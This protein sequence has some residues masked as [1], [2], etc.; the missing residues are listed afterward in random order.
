MGAAIGALDPHAVAHLHLGGQMRA[1]APAGNQ[2]DVKLQHLPARH[3]GHGVG[4]RRQVGEG[5]TGE[6]PGGELQRLLGPEVE[7]LDERAHL[8]DVGDLRGEAADRQFQTDGAAQPSDVYVAARPGAA[9]KHEAGSLLGRAERGA[10]VVLHGDV[11]RQQQALAG[12][13]LAGAAAVWEGHA[14]LQRGLQ[15]GCLAGLDREGPLSNG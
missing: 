12:A 11:A 3:A 7:S 8:L 5:E 4:P 10:V 15:D 13:A 2:A 9:G 1:D 6:L 14:T